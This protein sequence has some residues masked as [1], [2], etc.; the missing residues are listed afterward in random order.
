MLAGL[1]RGF[2]ME[3]QNDMFFTAWYGVYHRP[4]R[5]LTYAAAA[6]PAAVLLGTEAA[7]PVLLG[8]ESLMLGVDEVARY[9]SAGVDVPPGGR[10]YV[11]SDGAFEVLKADGMAWSY[12]E[13]VACLGQPSGDGAP[14]LDL[15]RENVQRVH[16]RADLPDDFSIL[17]L[18]FH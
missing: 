10:L 13:F 6:H 1:N 12:D 16:G 18:T 8:G 3:T 15:L 4:T 14:E 11:F 5:R 17:R 9:P 2:Q 7:V